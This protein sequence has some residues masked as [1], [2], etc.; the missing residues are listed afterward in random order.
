MLRSALSLKH[1]SLLFSLILI[2]FPGQVIGQKAIVYLQNDSTLLGRI[3]DLKS[4]DLLFISDQS[5]DTLILRPANV[6]RIAVAT[7]PGSTRYDKILLSFADQG[8]QNY[9]FEPDPSAKGLLRF[10]LDDQLYLKSNDQLI[11]PVPENKSERKLL[12]DQLLAESPR[13]SSPGLYGH[14]PSQIRRFANYLANPTTKYPT[15]YWLGQ[16]TVGRQNLSRPHLGEGLE[17][18][19]G[20]ADAY[21]I[22]SYSISIAR[23]HP[24]SQTG[25]IN[26]DLVVGVNLKSL[27]FQEEEGGSIYAYTSTASFLNLGGHI[28]YSFFRQSVYPFIG[29]G[30]VFQLLLEQDGR[31]ARFSSQE[32][33]ILLNVRLLETFSSSFILPTVLLG[34]EFPLQQRR[35]LLVELSLGRDWQTTAQQSFFTA[36]SIGYNFY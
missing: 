20:P 2:H 21:P 34:A 12:Y 16:I 27:R 19:T 29:I 22:N 1:F 14:R 15:S 17:S 28:R 3:V 30:G 36:L 33:D 11:H 32:A 24:L 23:N 6:S 25:R 4:A 26:T 13:T 31:L 5:R 8:Y 10:R 7:K 9:F 35:Y 18:L